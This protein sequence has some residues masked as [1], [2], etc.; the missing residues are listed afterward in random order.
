MRQIVDRNAQLARHAAQGEQPL[1]GLFQA[2]GLEVEGGGGGVDGG[3]GL[4][5]LDQGAVQ[6]L[7]RDRQA[8]RRRGLRA[9]AGLQNAFAG[10]LQGAQRLSE[11][12]GDGVA[13]QMVAGGGDFRQRLFR[14]A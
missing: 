12:T 5:G 6:G 4:R 9:G 1:L 2:V 7:G 8:R 11:A 10:P 14:R 3:R 13:A